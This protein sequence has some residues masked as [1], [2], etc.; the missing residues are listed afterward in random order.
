MPYKKATFWFS[1]ISVLIGL[2][3]YWGN[4]EKN[5]LLIGLNPLLSSMAYTEPFRHWM[6]DFES[7]KL[8]AD[9]GAIRILLPTYIIH[10][11]SFFL[12]GL[13]IDLLIRMIRKLS[14]WQKG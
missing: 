6:F 2:N 14:G 5:I 9:S 11:A 10:F 13:I 12:A 1:V 7:A 4:D 8:A 3:N